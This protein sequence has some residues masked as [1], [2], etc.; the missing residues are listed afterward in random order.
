MPKI[1]YFDCASGISG[2]MTLGAL[3]D[4]GV[5]P[6]VLNKELKRLP[7]KGWKLEA[8]SVKR[9]GIAGT[10]AHVI[11]SKSAIQPH[12]H[13]SHIKEMLDALSLPG[14]SLK[15]AQKAFSLLAKAEAAVHQIPIERV[16]FHEVGAVDAIIDIVG[17]M[18]GIEILGADRFHSSPVV[19][20]F[21]EVE[22]AHGV[23]PV[24]APATA[25][26]L[27]GMPIESGPVAMEMTT[28]TGA[29]ILAS[30]D[31]Q[32]GGIPQMKLGKTAYGAGGR[33]I[34]GRTNYLRV[35]VGEKIARQDADSLHV[36]HLCQLTT[37]IDDMNPEWY[38][39][40]LDRLFAAGCL[41]ASLESIQ[42]KKN[43]PGVRVSVLAEPGQREAMIEILL[44][45]SSTFGVKVASVERYCLPRKHE[46]IQTRFGSVGIKIGFLN[47]SILKVT[48]EYEDCRKLADKAAIP[49]GL[50]YQASM[51]AI[52]Q[53][54]PLEASHS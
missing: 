23:L 11:L 41:D 4:A 49:I 35:L 46:T 24:P 8:E 50:V 48:P 36:S 7:L 44:R 25:R 30:L 19:T 3:L 9:M 10:R 16:H 21:G 27:E 37:E 1:L 51:E 52:A 31:P 29:A 14:Q 15:R 39:P 42:M 18:I 33:E 47:G 34:H 13:Y 38:G 26:L 12:R 54:Y 53:K 22:C 6:K 20:G 28:P 17:S 2:D 40:L 5:D 45:H 43:R 32:F